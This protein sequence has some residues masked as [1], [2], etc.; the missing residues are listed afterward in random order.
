M[1]VCPYIEKKRGNTKF[2]I[3][4]YFVGDHKI[5]LSFLAHIELF[6][7]SS[8]SDI[9]SF[10]RDRHCIASYYMNRQCL[11][12]DL[13]A[14]TITINIPISQDLFPSTMVASMNNI[15]TL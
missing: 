3:S 7:S 12:K 11:R 8:V 6:S 10:S 14:R 2:A 9:V 5:F 1:A 13:E 15:I 4:S